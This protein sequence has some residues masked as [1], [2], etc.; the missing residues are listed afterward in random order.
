MPVLATSVPTLDNG[1]VVLDEAHAPLVEFL[2]DGPTPIIRDLVSATA[3]VSR[4]RGQT[5]SA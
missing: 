5:V 3:V 2:P 1:G 4:T